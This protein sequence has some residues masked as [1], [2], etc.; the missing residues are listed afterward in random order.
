MNEIKRCTRCLSLKPLRDFYKNRNTRDGVSSWCKTCTSVYNKKRHKENPGLS[1]EYRRNLVRRN[2]Q[3]RNNYLSRNPCAECGNSEVAVLVFDHIGPKPKK[4]NVS[5][6][7]YSSYS[8]ETIQEE[9]DKCQVLCANCHAR[10]HSLERM[11]IDAE[12]YPYY[13]EDDEQQRDA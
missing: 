6:L 4:K 5:D 2:L 10:R 3:F 11:Y 1:R 12:K 13:N 7:V 9:I 8:T